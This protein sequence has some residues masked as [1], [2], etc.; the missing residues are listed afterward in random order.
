M[1]VLTPEI[2]GQARPPTRWL[3]SRGVPNSQV[4]AVSVADNGEKSQ[5]AASAI[6][7]KDSSNIMEISLSRQIS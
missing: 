7:L 3:L 2:S 4:C 6:L 1:S 5:S